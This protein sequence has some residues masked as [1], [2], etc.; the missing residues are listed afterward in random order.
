MGSHFLL[1]IQ[2]NNKKR[3]CP[4]SLGQKRLLLRY[5]LNSYETRMHFF[6]CQT[7]LVS[8]TGDS[9]RAL[10]SQSLSSHPYESIRQKRVCRLPTDQR[11]SALRLFLITLLNQRFN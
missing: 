1:L 6:Q 9:R 3:F 5:H 10:L 4:N 7:H 2:F 8:V 11:L